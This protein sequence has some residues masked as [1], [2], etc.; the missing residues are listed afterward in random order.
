MTSP[1]QFKDYIQHN[2][3]IGKHEFSYNLVNYVFFRYECGNNEQP[4]RK[5]RESGIQGDII[6]DTIPINRRTGNGL[7]V[8]AVEAQLN[9][10]NIKIIKLTGRILPLHLSYWTADYII[11]PNPKTEFNYR[12]SIMGGG[13]GLAQFSNHLKSQLFWINKFLILPCTSPK[14]VQEVEFRADFL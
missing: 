4:A 9:R 10:I 5:V 2:I 8:K 1:C 14:F 13:G 6:C 11:G 7:I 3:Y 12:R